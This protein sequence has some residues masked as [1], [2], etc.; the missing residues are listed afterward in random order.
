MPR[1]SKPNIVN[2]VRT[3]QR[4]FPK[5]G[6]QPLPWP[7]IVAPGH[8]Y[9]MPERAAKE[10]VA[11]LDKELESGEDGTEGKWSGNQ[12][13]YIRELRA[14]WFQRAHG[15]DAHYTKHGTFPRP[16]NAEP[17]TSRDVITEQARRREMEN[18]T[19]ESNAE[20]WRR[21]HMTRSLRVYLITKRW[22]KQFGS[23][24]PKPP[25]D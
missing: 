23:K 8:T 17:P 6:G 24:N 2:G 4:M 11:V 7:P 14:K 25:E 18:G 19:Y 12:R 16:M 13:Q 15:E 1:W 10:Y 3:P 5:Y 9:P 20:H 21:H 22:A